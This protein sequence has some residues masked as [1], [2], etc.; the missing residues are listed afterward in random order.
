MKR[1]L[2][3]LALLPFAPPGAVFAGEPTAAPLPAWVPRVEDYTLMWWAEGFP[4]HTPSAPWRRVIQTGR[5]ALALDTETLRIPHF[6]AVPTGVG[7]ATAAR[8][9]NRTWQQLPPADLSLRILGS[10]SRGVSSNAPTSLIWSSPR[11]MVRS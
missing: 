4:S 3:I 10:L 5:Y 2:L 7:Y 11:R 8:A 6:G 9:D 1:V